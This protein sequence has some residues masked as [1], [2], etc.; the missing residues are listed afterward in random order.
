M[1]EFVVENHT[2]HFIRIEGFERKTHN[3]ETG[4]LEHK[5][6]L[7]PETIL[8][9]AFEKYTAFQIARGYHATDPE[10]IFLQRY[11]DSVNIYFDD[12]KVLVQV[13]D[14]VFY[15]GNCP[16]GILDIDNNYTRE[17]RNRKEYRYT[18]KITEKHYQN[19][20]FIP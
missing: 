17:K 9:P 1:D 5:K 18:Y 2:C 8:I 11:I 14:S 13:C 19:A 6:T 10:S 12:K 20:E 16:T 7:N 3:P 15:N 4:V